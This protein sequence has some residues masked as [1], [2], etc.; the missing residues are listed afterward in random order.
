MIENWM[1]EELYRKRMNG[2][3]VKKEGRKGNGK[4]D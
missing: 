3:R 1:K 4:L 2:G